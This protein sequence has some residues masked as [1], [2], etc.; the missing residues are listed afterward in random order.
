MQETK[1]LCK[2]D[3]LTSN[4]ILFTIDMQSTKDSTELE[5]SSTEVT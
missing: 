2:H 3:T 4:R 5:S 1:K